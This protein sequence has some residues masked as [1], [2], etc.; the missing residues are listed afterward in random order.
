MDSYL[1]VDAKDWMLSC[2][3]VFFKNYETS[4]FKLAI[5]EVSAISVSITNANLDSE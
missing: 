3:T 2:V 4:T 5:V 1:I